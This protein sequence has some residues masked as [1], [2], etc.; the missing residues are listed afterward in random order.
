[1]ILYILHHRASFWGGALG[2]TGVHNR[3]SGLFQYPIGA[4]VEKSVKVL[5]GAIPENPGIKKGLMEAWELTMS[6]V[7]ILSG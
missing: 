6:R 7:G 2:G 1:M 5:P 3:L 4:S